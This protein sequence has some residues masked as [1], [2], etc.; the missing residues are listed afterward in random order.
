MELRC[1]SRPALD[2]NAELHQAEADSEFEGTGMASGLM[3]KPQAGSLFKACVTCFPCSYNLLLFIN[4]KPRLA[5]SI[6]GASAI[7]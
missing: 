6:S 2:C 5:L 1:P 4:L 3:T 7:Y